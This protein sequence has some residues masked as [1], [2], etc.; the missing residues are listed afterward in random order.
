MKLPF[1]TVVKAVKNPE[2][3]GLMEDFKKQLPE[4]QG[5]REKIRQL[6]NE[7]VARLT[8]D[9]FNES[10]TADI[11]ITYINAKEEICKLYKDSDA[12]VKGVLMWLPRM[13]KYQDKLK[14]YISKE[15]K[16][17]GLEL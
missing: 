16:K 15:R 6:L 4:C 11:I 12:Q 14:E 10:Y 2:L 9:T 5:K 1:W 3:K 13:V 7:K 8:E 17:Y